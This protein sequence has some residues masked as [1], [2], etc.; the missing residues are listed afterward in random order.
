[1]QYTRLTPANSYKSKSWGVL[2]SLGGFLLGGTGV[3]CGSV[4]S[5]V[6]SEVGASVEEVEFL[7]VANLRPTL[8]VILFYQAKTLLEHSLKILIQMGLQVQELLASFPST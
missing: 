5:R 4:S 2:R 3:S 7:D 6:M 1:M 8:M